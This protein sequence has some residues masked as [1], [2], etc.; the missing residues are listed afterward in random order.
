MLQTIHEFATEQLVS[1]GELAQ[2]KEAHASWFL[3][4]ALTAIVDE[5]EERFVNKTLVGAVVSRYVSC[6]S[7]L[8][9]H[10]SEFE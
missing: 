9:V 7:R 5:G 10:I 1:S 6:N 2:A 4:L 8:S 3:E